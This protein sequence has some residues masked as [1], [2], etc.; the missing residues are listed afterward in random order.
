MATMNRRTLLKVA[1]AGAAAGFGATLLP[2]RAEA[3]TTLSFSSWLP[4]KHPIVVNAF[5]P[6][7]DDVHKAT[8]GRVKVRILPKPLG[9]APSH[10]DMARDGVADITYGLHSFTPGDRFLLSRVA[11][12]SFLG[13]NAAD[14]S[15]AYWNAYKNHLAQAKEHAGV[16]TLGVFNHGPGALH[17]NVRPVL[18]VA[19]LQG[20]TLRVPGGYVA[21]LMA[22]LGTV[23]RQAP[24]PEVYEMLSNGVIQGVAFTMEAL[25][26]FKLLDH[27]KY[28]TTVPGG[29]Y[30]TSWFFVMNQGKWDGLTDA[31]KEAI[32]KLSG[33]AFA[34]RVGKAWIGADEAAMAQILKAGITISP[35]A[36][37]FVTELIQRTNTLEGAWAEQA[38]ARGVDGLALLAEIRKAT[39]V[40]LPS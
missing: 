22:K 7:A 6:W 29:I 33:E 17:N 20:M 27:L 31:D 18:K 21:D 5:E 25:T 4:P 38:K 40:V 28:T 10:F 8:D 24:S 15:V 1:G 13:D 26:S 23:V 39:G 14:L 9:G 2:R 30:N 37:A 11:E 19:D 12:F 34:R 32:D 36:P 3:A 35:A 16:H